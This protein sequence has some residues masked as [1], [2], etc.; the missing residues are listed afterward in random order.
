MAADRVAGGGARRRVA[1]AVGGTARA[2]AA[3]GDRCPAAA[4]VR[5]VAAVLALRGAPDASGTPQNAALDQAK[6]EAPHDLD[7]A[8]TQ[9]E[10][11]LA[12][13]PNDQ[14]GWRLLSRS[15][16]LVGNK[17]KAEAAARKAA[18]L[19]PPGGGDATQKSAAGE[20]LVEAAGGTVGPDARKQFE[21]ALAADPGDPRARFF[22]GLADAQDGH[23]DAALTRWLALEADSPADA[24]WLDG[25]HANIDRLAAQNN[26][27]PDEMARRRG[28][29]AKAPVAPGPTASDMAAAAAMAPDDRQAMIK[30]MVQ[31]LADRLAHEPGD[32]DGW[33]R[34]GRAYDV[35]GDKEK[36]L[37][38][39]RR[40]AAA[41]PKRDDARAAYESAQ[42]AL[43][44]TKTR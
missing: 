27:A 12:K 34:L 21:A 5:G 28:A 15:Y 30:S 38:A 18:A 10:A 9:L 36:S 24:P 33:L 40:A 42:A 17:E 2:A 39:Y 37:D 35:L 14:D 6:K 3:L 8:I 29:L 16:T 20:D 7:T 26:I 31:R 13:E 22:L 11:R 1:A 43:G 41:D 44:E 32:V 23:A 19:T 25:L 4:A